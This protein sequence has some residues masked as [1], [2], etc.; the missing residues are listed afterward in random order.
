VNTSQLNDEYERVEI[1][2]T[3]QWLPA[4]GNIHRTIIQAIKGLDG[5]V[6]I[7]AE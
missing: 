7:V 5:A 3:E 1:A 6:I 4:P 2:L